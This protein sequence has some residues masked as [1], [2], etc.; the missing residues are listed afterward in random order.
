[1]QTQSSRADVTSA[2]KLNARM[3]ANS[4]ATR[5]F[6][7]WCFRQLPTLPL[8]ARLLDLGCGTGKQTQL[9]AP[10]FSPQSEIVGLDLS[11]DALA[12]LREQY[13]GRAKLSLVEGSFDE[14]EKYPQLSEGSF[15][16]I[17]G[18]YALYYTQNLGKLME[19][20][21]RLLK[22]GGIF[23][24]ISPYFG[25]NDEFLRILRPLHEVEAFMDYVFDEFHQEII[26]HG[27]RIGFQS[28]KPALLRNQIH[29]PSAEAFLKYLSNSLFYRPGH[30]E[31]I[32]AEVQKVVA[33]QGSFAVSKN[34]ISLQLQKPGAKS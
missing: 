17:F 20:S 22:P 25:T 1:M 18:G 7:E 26:A 33:A 29:F 31:A 32:L 2:Q 8:P 24:N 6:D 21:F 10:M 28:V 12:Q 16:L 30:D 3:S 4:N 34:V 11:G 23:W 5:D 14:M 27:E 19:D 13:Q 9:F 15:D